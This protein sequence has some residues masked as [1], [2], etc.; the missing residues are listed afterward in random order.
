MSV[1]K[2]SIFNSKLSGICLDFSKGSAAGNF[3][4]KLRKIYR[5]MCLLAETFNEGE[6]IGLEATISDGKVRVFTSPDLR[7][8]TAFFR[9]QLADGDCAG[10]VRCAVE[11]LGT[12]VEQ[13]HTFRLQGDIRL[14]RRFVVYDG[15][16]FTI[17]GNR[18]E[19]DVAIQRLFCTKARQ[20]L[21]DTNLCQF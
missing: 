6:F 1:I 17:A 15:S 5:T 11:I 13:Q 16:M 21:I 19:G 20:F 4:S 10:D 9:S 12:A 14:W 8:E 7:I 3:D 18:V 2:E